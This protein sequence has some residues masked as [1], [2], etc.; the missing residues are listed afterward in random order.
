M[1]DFAGWGA[2]PEASAGLRLILAAYDG[3]KLDLGLRPQV[4]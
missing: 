1:C 3:P 2:W 4:W